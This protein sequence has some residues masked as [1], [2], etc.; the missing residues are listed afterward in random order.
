MGFTGVGRWRDE[1]VERLAHDDG[2]AE[3]RRTPSGSHPGDKH[4]E[5]CSE[6]SDTATHRG[7]G[8]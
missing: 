8:V 3:L 1:R 6:G 7:Y 5:V 2:P 4:R